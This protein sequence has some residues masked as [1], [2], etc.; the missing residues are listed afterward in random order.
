MTTK[1]EKF[2]DQL[3]SSLEKIEQY[4][5]S[6]NLCII[7]TS[8]Y[9]RGY[10]FLIILFKDE[11][12]LENLSK[13]IIQ[14]HKKLNKIKNKKIKLM[15][16]FL[17]LIKRINFKIL[18][19][20]TNHYDL[21]YF[22]SGDEEIKEK[23]NLEREFAYFLNK[24]DFS[25]TIDRARREGKEL[26]LDRVFLKNKSFIEQLEAILGDDK[27]VRSIVEKYLAK[28]EQ[29]EI[30]EVILETKKINNLKI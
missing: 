18:Y 1:N 13:K 3:F 21:K 5:K 26:K 27:K 6:N 19:I 23:A 8:D 29:K 12:T 11:K 2:E 20:E 7:R 25:E 16:M 17:K 28:K 4:H 30:S 22:K 15:R 24:L 9:S 10:S 14:S